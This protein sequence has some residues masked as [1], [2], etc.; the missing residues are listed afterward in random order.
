MPTGHYERKPRV[1]RVRIS[2]RVCGIERTV[3]P[4]F[5]ARITGNYCSSACAGAGSRTLHGKSCERCGSIFRPHR[6]TT[7]FC[8]NVCRSAARRA[9]NPKWKDPEYVREYA[10]NYQHA[11]RIR[12]NERHLEARTAAKAAAEAVKIDDLRRIFAKAEQLCVYCGEQSSRLTIDHCKPIAM[13]GKHVADNLIPCCKS[14]NSSKGTKDLSDWLDSN[15]GTMGL[16]RA[17][18]FLERDQIDPSFYPLKGID[19]EVVR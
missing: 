4:S 7:K 18:V 17:I 2:C 3:L 9:A 8:S 14:C 1:E 13:G 5:A 15:H 6:K 12:T 19:V 10:R 16:A 11:Y